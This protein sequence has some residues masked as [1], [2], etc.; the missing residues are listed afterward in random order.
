MAT[1]PRNTAPHERRP[2]GR[3]AG[4]SRTTLDRRDTL[5]LADGALAAGGLLR[6]PLVLAL[7]PVSA[8]T[9]WAG[10]RSGRFPA[11]VKVTDRC[12]AWR[13]EDIAA[14]LQSFRPEAQP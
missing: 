4:H 8:S 10:V 12:T 5:A 11:G 1:Q 13:S 9:W 3:R 2:A 7:I 14:L 6:L